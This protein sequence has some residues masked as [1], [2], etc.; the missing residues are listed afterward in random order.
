MRNKK[1][2]A[3]LQRYTCLL[4]SSQFWYVLYH[5]PAQQATV[6]PLVQQGFVLHLAFSWVSSYYHIPREVTSPNTHKVHLFHFLSNIRSMKSNGML[7]RY[8]FNKRNKI[9]LSM[10][11]M[12]PFTT[13]TLWMV[14]PTPQQPSASPH[15]HRASNQI[16]FLK[17]CE[18]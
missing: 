6:A 9:S 10:G 15:T 4:R 7:L 5:C 8:K 16:V 18:R 14:P 12:V 11:L 13:V 17:I 1:L 3:R 2:S